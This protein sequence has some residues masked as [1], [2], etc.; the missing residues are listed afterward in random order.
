MGPD[1]GDMGRPNIYQ[2][3]TATVVLNTLDVLEA[4][5]F[6]RRA[7]G[8]HSGVAVKNV[9]LVISQWVQRRTDRTYLDLSLGF[10][11]MRPHCYQRV[12]KQSSGGRISM[13]GVTLGRV[14]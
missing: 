12:T 9:T 2:C 7:H 4:Q 8:W 14:H 5:R 6:N 3:V 1:N 11:G 10:M 13:R